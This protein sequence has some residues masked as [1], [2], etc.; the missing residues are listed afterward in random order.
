MAIR[1]IDE[2]PTTT[3]APVKSRIQYIDDPVTE[4]VASN[5]LATKFIPQLT[6]GLYESLPFGK[7]IVS[8][9]PNA[10]SIQKLQEEV[11][12]PQTGVATAG[13]M[14]GEAA[15]DIAM[16]SPAMGAAGA[17]P[18]IPA[19]LR[20]AAGMGAFSGAKEALT[21]DIKNSPSAALSGVGSGLLMGALGKL[22][23]TAIPKK[24]PGAERIGSAL[25]GAA[26]GALTSEPGK[27]GE[28]AAFMGGLGALFPSTRIKPPGD[29][30]RNKTL[31]I[32]E[33]TKGF[34]KQEMDAYGEAIDNLPNEVGANKKVDG[35]P[36]IENLEKVLVERQL[37]DPASGKV[38]NRPLAEA[39]S[40]LLKSYEVLS[41]KYANGDGTLDVSDVIDEYRNIRGPKG[42]K[43][44]NPDRTMAANE[45]FAGV[46]NLINSEKFAAANARYREF[47]QKMEALNKYFDVEGGNPALTEKGERFIKNKLGATGEA[48]AIE[49]ILNKDLGEKTTGAR[50]LSRLRRFANSPVVRGGVITGATLTGLSK[51]FGRRND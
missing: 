32:R 12:D 41:R 5:P 3:T 4:N 15:P 18:K 19:F 43:S 39:D 28:N 20:A 47:K 49:E 36:V 45:L 13:R 2:T 48:K 8:M 27:E 37:I 38:V 21:G 40:K 42:R 46:K 25:G 24:L 1:Y 11:P 30:A 50:Y 16:A 33:K 34:K 23:A 44:S 29:Y 6:K 7:R 14:V 10:E 35:T 22:G 17:I 26:A 31:S 9:L 51:L